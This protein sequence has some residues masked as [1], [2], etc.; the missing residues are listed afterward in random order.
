MDLIARSQADAHARILGAGGRGINLLAPVEPLVSSHAIGVEK[1]YA[2]P[3]GSAAF[4]QVVQ[5]NLPAEII[6]DI[7]L[8]TDVAAPDS[9]NFTQ[10]PGLCMVTDVE[11]RSGSNTLQ[12]FRNIPATRALL[13]KMESGK[14]DLVLKLA[15]G[16]AHN[17]GACV[18]PIPAAWCSASAAFQ[19]GM[20]PLDCRGTGGLVVRLTL[21]SVANLLNAGASGASGVNSCR[22][23]YHAIHAADYEPQ[24][25]LQ[26]YLATDIATIPQGASHAD[27]ASVSYNLKGLY[28]VL[29][30]LAVLHTLASDVDTAHDYFNSPE[31]L[32]ALEVLIDGRSF[33]KSD[34]QLQLLMDALS[35]AGVGNMG[36]G[37]V[38]YVP[39][40]IG[41]DAQHFAGGLDTANLQSFT[42]SVTH[43]SGAAAYVDFVGF[44]KIHIIRQGNAFV[45]HK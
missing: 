13:Y 37:V 3:V 33:W 18:T 40:G 34:D 15:G 9:G 45:V 31:D 21:N 20:P 24:A 36:S 41:W 44:R 1:R 25:S 35:L 38:S 30:E 39:F 26:P 32:D 12:Q 43:N 19:H 7:Y 10:Y 17:S 28:G 16:A 23:Y 6:G 27:G 8:E 29:T 4:G 14:R 2:S 5:F 11:I 22:L 42:A